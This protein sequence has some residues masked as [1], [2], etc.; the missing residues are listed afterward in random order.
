MGERCATCAAHACI[1][2]CATL[3][4]LQDWS[5]VLAKGLNG[6]KLVMEGEVEEDKAVDGPALRDAVDCKWPLSV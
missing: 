3:V 5:H 4:S 1:E 2:G 6:L